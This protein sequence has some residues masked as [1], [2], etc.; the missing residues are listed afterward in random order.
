[1]P[2]G[3]SSTLALFKG[4]A[5][6][7]LAWAAVSF[8]LVVLDC[9]GADPGEATSRLRRQVSNVLPSAPQQHVLQ[10]FHVDP[11]TNDGARV[12]QS[13]NEQWWMFAMSAG[14]RMG[15]SLAAAS[16]QDRA[17]GALIAIGGTST[18]SKAR[19]NASIDAFSFS[20]GPD[21]HRFTNVL[22][23]TKPQ[24][25]LGQTSIA[26]ADFSGDG[27]LD[28]LVG[29]PQHPSRGRVLFLL[30]VSNGFSPPI[31]LERPRGNIRELGVSLAA[32]GDV[33]G[34]GYVDAIVGAPHSGTPG[35]G[36]EGAVFLHLGGPG[37]L[38]STSVWSHFGG[39]FERRLGYGV[40]GAGDVNKDGYADV[41]VGAPFA[42]NEAIPR[43][44]RACL[45]L[46]S[47][48]GL[49]DKPA[50]VWKGTLPYGMA[51]WSL[52][53]IGDVNGDGRPDIA[54][55]IP[56]YEGRP[57]G[58]GLVAVFHGSDQG[59]PAEPDLMLQTA[60]PHAL[61]G[62]CLAGVGDL[63]A[64]GFSDLVVGAPHFS[65]GPELD[66]RVYVHLG[67]RNGLRPEP[68]WTIEGGQ[69]GALCGSSVC[70][71]GDVNSDRCND[72]AVGTPGYNGLVH[73]QGRVDVFLGST[74]THVRVS[75]SSRTL[76]SEPRPLVHPAIAWGFALTAVLGLGILVHYFARER[77]RV[78]QRERERIA[79]DLHD[80]L[81]SRLAAV[82]LLMGSGVAHAPGTTEAEQHRQKVQSAAS[83]AI[84]AME[85][86]VWS[87]KPA[88]DTV[89]NL[90]QFITQYAVPFCA[91]AGI[92]CLYH[93]PAVLPHRVLAPD[94]RKHIFLTVKE[95]L[96]NVIKHSGATEVV[97][98]AELAND[99]L[100]IFVAD[101]GRGIGGDRVCDEN[102]GLR[103]MRTRMTQLGG[104]LEIGP[105]EPTG[106]IVRIRAPLSGRRVWWL[107]WLSF[108]KQRT[109]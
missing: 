59:L 2:N 56:G 22:V 80:D 20:T 23:G 53:A 47:R 55:G 39:R 6:V 33:N 73:K 41:L 104:V 21:G 44:G 35:A 109:R 30:G 18:G 52:A 13:T 102:D 9:K 103:N 92:Q 91:P 87:V 60:S 76:D 48:T 14:A 19:R 108:R 50:W 38:S 85:A 27:R 54:V 25:G 96:T 43:A 1:M 88:N 69:K 40:A 28:M 34:D 16:S 24:G 75:P 46:G 67:S 78:A 17:E 45:F 93:L 64:D 70:A 58:A 61:Y 37:G 7:S 90:I 57:E 83:E 95:A 32:A 68:I 51:G 81:G 66:G 3:S 77:R 72:F 94:R 26:I 86:I 105:N 4:R 29:D 74:S 15:Q 100:R 101:N 71:L 106:T 42:E 107:E 10:P 11:K 98:G 99:E 62:F 63:D 79:R 8:G 82:Q 65:S 12:V 49:E 5:V 31:S 84:E 97:I 36:L 89:E